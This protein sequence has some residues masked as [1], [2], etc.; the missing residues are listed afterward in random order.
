MFEKAIDFLAIGDTAT[1]A[2]IRIKEASVHCIVNTERCEICMRFGDK[3]P[4]ESV[5]EVR[6]VG[7]SANAAVSA[8]RLGLTTA[9]VSNVGDDRVGSE[10]VASITENGVSAEY[11]TR[12]SGYASNYHYVLRY[13]AERTILIKQT[14]FPYSLPEFSEPPRWIYFSSVGENALDFHKEIAAYVAAHPE[15]KLA[16]QPGTYQIKLCASGAI[17]EL[18]QVT[19]LFF[20]NKEEAQKILKSKEN[21]IPT[22]MQGLRAL[23]PKTVVVTDGPRGAFATDG[24]SIWMIPAYPDPK[25][26][27]DRTGAGD[28]FA[29]TVTAMLA[30]GLPL[31]E[32]L[33]RG[34][35]NSM[36]VVQYIGAQEGLLSREQLEQFLKDAPTDFKAGAIA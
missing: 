4:Y 33:I 9:L 26:P 23:G 5:T 29:S 17:P 25:P 27:V 2:F 14:E 18:L 36:S 8:K 15:T 12:H 19:E 7:N 32:A 3:I 10:C 21:D 22:L 16:F 6:G 34:P 35:I 1:D 20:C 30:Q 13:E 11:I 24:T 31:P 28:S